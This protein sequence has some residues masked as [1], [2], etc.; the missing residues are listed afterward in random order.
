MKPCLTSSVSKHCVKFLTIITKLL[1]S[2]FVGG[3]C[4]SSAGPQ[5]F[6][7]NDEPDVD[8][9]SDPSEPYTSVSA[10]RPSAHNY[11]SLSLS[12]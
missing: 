4:V 5:C 11:I 8:F 12:D 7:L 6:F 9:T 10:L 3:P 1:H 2:E